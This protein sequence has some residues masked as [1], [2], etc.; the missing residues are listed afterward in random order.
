MNKPLIYSLEQIAQWAYDNK[1]V[2]IPALQRGLVWKPRQV[3]MLWDSLLR[4]FPIGN[5]ILLDVPVQDKKDGQ[6]YLLDGQQRY[7]AISLGHMTVPDPKAILWVDI[8]PEKKKSSTRT[9]LVKVTTDAHPWGF[10]N[11]DECSTLNTCERRSALKEFGFNRGNIYNNS[12]S[13]FQTWPYKALK[14]VPLYCFLRATICSAEEFYVD[15][16]NTFKE[17]PFSY[18]D[19]MCFDDEDRHYIKTYLYNAF[20]NLKS[21]HLNCIHLPNEVIEKETDELDVGQTT[22]EV[23]FTRL[24]T[25]GTRI[26]QD[27]LNYSA[28]KAYWPAIKDENDQL[29]EKYMNP[30]KLVMLAFRLVLTKNTDDDLKSELSIKQIRSL[31]KDPKQRELIMNLYSNNKLQDILSL[32]DDWLGVSGNSPDRTPAILRTSIA[33]RSSDVYLLLMYFAKNTLEGTITLSPDL[34]KALALTLHWFYA[35]DK[36]KAVK[37]IFHCCMQ[38][39]NSVQTNIMKGI[40]S[41]QHNCGILPIYSPSE[42]KKFFSIE[43]SSR[44]KIWSNDYGPWQHF[45]NRVFWYGTEEAK[46]MLLYAERLYINTHF[47]NYNPARQDLWEDYNRPWDFDHITPQDW[48]N[49]KRHKYRDFDKQW[50]NSIGNIAAISYEV[51]R[52]KGNREDYKEY[53]ENK[54]TLLYNSDSEKISDAITGNR[55]QSEAFAKITFKR[56]CAIYSVTYNIIGC[57]FKDL[58]LSDTL[59]ERKQLFQDIMHEIPEAKAYFATESERE[60]EVCREQDWNREWIGV[61]IV[62]SNFY[63]CFEWAAYKNNGLP[64]YCEIGIR[65]APK[66]LIKEQHCSLFKEGFEKFSDNHWW[67]QCENC[68]KES[69]KIANIVSKLKELDGIVKQNI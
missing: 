32:I 59:L 40:S 58:V 3:E 45:F 18:K 23:L 47:S 20:K 60:Y 27:D 44:W 7:N 12:F 67:Y 28:I 50:L 22:L 2:K 29:A 1:E 17:S 41:A 26:S 21:Y 48:I 42:M 53:Q 8:K 66:V 62:R 51:N 55:E 34:I 65:K 54:D 9:F 25:G 63:S 16:V 37:E 13:L 68:D 38:A 69:I 31:S 19:K 5:F 49:G 33:H 43:C 39:G 64:L 56:A 4:G 10:H 30:S 15:V 14:P 57:L 6:Y 11:D 61:G 46:E 52:S 24:N 35:N 36:H